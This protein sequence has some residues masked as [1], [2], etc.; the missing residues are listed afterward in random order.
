MDRELRD[1]NEE[2]KHMTLAEDMAAVSE[3]AEE[4]IADAL[5]EMYSNLETL[6]RDLRKRR[7]NEWQDH[8]TW[9]QFEKIKQ[10]A[11]ER[12]NSDSMPIDIAIRSAAL[13]AHHEYLKAND[14]AEWQRVQDWQ[15]QRDREE[16]MNRDTIC[17]SGGDRQASCEI[18]TRWNACL[19][20]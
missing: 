4:I 7:E 12:L 20:G 3:H 9:A 19:L 18:L 2:A 6:M 5:N 16:H 10:Q 1:W 11:R 13:S 8:D 14:P 15:K 17:G